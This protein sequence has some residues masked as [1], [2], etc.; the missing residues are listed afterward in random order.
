MNSRI[1]GRRIKTV[2]QTAIDGGDADSDSTTKELTL[3]ALCQAGVYAHTIQTWDDKPEAVQTLDNFKIRFNQQEKIYLRSLTA[4]ADGFHSANQVHT[5]VP[6]PHLIPHA[7]A[8]AAVPAFLSN[9]ISLYYCWTRGLSKNAEHTSALCQNK[10]T[11]HQDDATTLDNHKGGINK[12][13]F[14]KSGKKHA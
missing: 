1:C 5:P 7:A 3:G 14:G 10:N 11:N 6:A 13:N 8:A 12:I 9:D 4:K 2:R